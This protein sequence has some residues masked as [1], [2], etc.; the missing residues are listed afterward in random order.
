MIAILL[1]LY[2]TYYMNS[3]LTSLISFFNIFTEQN[4]KNLQDKTSKKKCQI[5]S[6]QKIESC[7]AGFWKVLSSMLVDPHR[8]YQVIEK[9]HEA[10]KQKTRKTEKGIN[11]SMRRG[12]L[13][14]SLAANL[15]DSIISIVN[16]LMV[17]HIELIIM[18]IK[19]FCI[20]NIVFIRMN[21]QY[22]KYLTNFKSKLKR[23]FAFHKTRF[24]N[25]SLKLIT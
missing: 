20:Y 22:Q 23:N 24:W 8:Q 3:R 18:N 16:V 10:K 25:S 15:P 11:K 17:F 1:R 13:H 5:Y 19:L 9:S 14:Q 2:L 7:T 6:I 12:C 21:F 4:K